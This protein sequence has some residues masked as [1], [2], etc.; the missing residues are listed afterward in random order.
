MKTRFHEPETVHVETS[1]RLENCLFCFEASLILLVAIP[2]GSVRIRECKR[3]PCPTSGC[4]VTSSEQ[5][6][7]RPR[8]KYSHRERQRAKVS[9]PASFSFKVRPALGLKTGFNFNLYE[10]PGANHHLRNERGCDICK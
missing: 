1:S 4:D 10:Y 8:A 5:V 7:R 6:L 2:A 9:S 3:T